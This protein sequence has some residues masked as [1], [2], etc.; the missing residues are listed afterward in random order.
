[1]NVEL[2]DTINLM[3]KEEPSEVKRDAVKSM[4]DFQKVEYCFEQ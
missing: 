2:E 3:L 4:K 1:M